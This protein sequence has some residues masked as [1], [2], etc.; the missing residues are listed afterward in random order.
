M[1]FKEFLKGEKEL[2]SKPDTY[3]HNPLSSTKGI[4]ARDHNDVKTS[5]TIVFNFK[6]AKLVSIG[7]VFEI[8]WANQYRI[9]TVVIIEKDGIMEDGSVNPHWHAFIKEAANYM[10]DDLEDAAHIVTTILTH[11][12]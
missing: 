4:F 2:N 6:G 10:V 12:I 9:P 11:G 7:T 8:A 5:D 3:N 1:R